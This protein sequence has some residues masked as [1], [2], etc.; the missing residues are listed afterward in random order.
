MASLWKASRMNGYSYK[1]KVLIQMKILSCLREQLKPKEK[2]L[3]QEHAE[4]IPL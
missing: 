3:F 1:N 2:L 4:R